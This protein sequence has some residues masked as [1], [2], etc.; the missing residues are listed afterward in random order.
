MIDANPPIDVIYIQPTATAGDRCID[1]EHFARHVDSFFRSAQS[2]NS[3]S[4]CDQWK[5]AAG[6]RPP[7]A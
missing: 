4:I 6:F 2:K 1:F 7:H 5:A 3:R